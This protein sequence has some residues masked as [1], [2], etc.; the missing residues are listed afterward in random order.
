MAQHTASSPQ[1]H[2]LHRVGPETATADE[3]IAAELTS[4]LRS[5]GAN[6][7]VP[8][9]TSRLLRRLGVKNLWMS[10]V[11][12]DD[13]AASVWRRLAGDSTAEGEAGWIGAAAAESLAKGGT[14]QRATPMG[15]A[16]AAAAPGASGRF[17]AL[18]TLAQ[19]S[20]RDR[21]QLL[22]LA[23]LVAGVH[24]ARQSTPPS[25]E[26]LRAL[27]GADWTTTLQALARIHSLQLWLFRASDS[28]GGAPTLVAEAAHGDPSR[29]GEVLPMAASTAHEALLTTTCLTSSAHSQTA[30][31]SL[32]LRTLATT[33]GHSEAWA[34]PL[35]R[36]D[37]PDGVLIACSRDRHPRE[38]LAPIAPYLI[39]RWQAQP[40]KVR[41]PGTNV[42]YRRTGFAAMLVAVLAMLWPTPWRS[43]SRCEIEA[44]LQRIVAAPFDATLAEAMAEPG[45]R[46]RA[47]DSL[48][49]LS[50]QALE[51]ELAGRVAEQ[52]REA[53]RAAIASAAGDWSGAQVAEL[54]VQRME[55]RI[56]LLREQLQQVELVS[57]IDGIVIRAEQHGQSGAPLR[58]GQPLFV[59]AGDDTHMLLHVP[60]S[61]AGT[62]REGGE[63]RA[64]LSAHPWR[65]LRGTI[66]RVH[67]AAELIDGR[68]VL[69]VETELDERLPWLRPGMQGAA[70]IRAQHRPRLWVWVEPKLTAW[71]SLWP[72]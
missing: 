67:P 63:V 29:D 59:I 56:E 36:A 53:K 71:R 21:L 2:L 41:R 4:A 42:L 9:F 16:M 48:G 54:Q 37:G 45:T 19:R 39:A 31:P 24:D 66:T 44:S 69:V 10:L 60:D 32:A 17:V 55:R 58:H 22:Q 43:V 50:P 70:W 47:G 28:E 52:Q 14:A 20:P 72:W 13:P 12:E 30:Q 1:P 23:A 64:R 5:D 35:P 65:T 15:F 33:T 61:L 62:V 3:S 6:P 34:L 38:S 11:L 18:A 68:N 51:T 49:R 25:A 40:N 7:R 26:L 8:Q 27:A 46:V 57:P